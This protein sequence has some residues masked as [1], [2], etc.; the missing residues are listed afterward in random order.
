MADGVDIM[1]GLGELGIIASGFQMRIFVFHM[2]G[3]RQ[4]HV[5][6]IIP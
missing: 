2:R 5:V 3:E 6:E 4:V 1:T